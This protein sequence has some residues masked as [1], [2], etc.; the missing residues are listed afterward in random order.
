MLDQLG[1]E[2]DVT[3]VDL[4]REIVRDR[5]F[6][7]D[8]HFSTEEP[9]PGSHRLSNHHIHGEDVGCDHIDNHCTAMSMF[10][11]NPP[12]PLVNLNILDMVDIEVENP[13]GVTI[14]DI[15]YAITEKYVVI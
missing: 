5:T 1:C 6:N 4:A 2:Q 15:L 10:A 7:A 13:T 3:L 11:T 14:W 9:L 12:L 8:I